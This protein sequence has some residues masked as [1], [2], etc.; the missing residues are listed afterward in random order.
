MC[1]IVCKP[2]GI[3]LPSK[4]RLERCFN[5]NK[6][7]AGFMFIEKNKVRIE[8]GYFTFEDFYKDL[9][10]SIK[11]DTPC[12]MHF[13]IGTHGTKSADNTHPFAVSDND[14]FLKNQRCYTDVGVAHNGIISLTSSSYSSHVNGIWSSDNT[15]DTY[16]FVK[17]YLSLII[18]NYK[19]YQDDNAL[20]LIEKLIGSSNKLAFLSKD[21]HIQMINNFIEDEGI[22]YSNSSYKPVETTT[23]TPRHKSCYSDI[24]YDWEFFRL[25]KTGYDFT[26]GACPATCEDDYSYCSR[27]SNKKSCLFYKS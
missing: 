22:F 9:K 19:F 24:G 11:L 7:G 16:K 21:G 25:D 3:K 14:M 1:I 26:V 15:S 4:E 27:C 6:D 23:I 5:I 17:E 2:A 12:V 20:K 10:H 13:R 18:E 8:R